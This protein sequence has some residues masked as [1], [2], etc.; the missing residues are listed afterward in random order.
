[1]AK[2]K[3]AKPDWDAAPRK[4]HANA[5]V[6]NLPEADQ[7]T[8]WLLLHPT[9][10]ETPPCTLEAAM[11]HLQEEFGVECAL[12]TFSEWHSWYSLKKRMEKAASRA[13]QATLEFAQDHPDATPD[14]L[15]KYGQM[16]FTAES[17]EH[18]DAKT[19]TAL[20]RERSRRMALELDRRK[21]V[22][23][24]AAAAEAKAK[25]A[26]IT[27]KAKSKGGLT[28]ETLAEIEEAAGLL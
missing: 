22:L 15:E 13:Q 17:I 18:G 9:D 20:V 16:I 1:M 26:A 2:R 3:K 24:E 25:L 8:L 12:S 6:K 7:E 4:T 5:K 27:Q 19:F 10:K 28:A 14:D 11:V 23:L 21:L